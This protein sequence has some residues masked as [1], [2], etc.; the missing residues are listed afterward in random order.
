MRV[1]DLLIC[2]SVTALWAAAAPLHAQEDTGESV[3]SIT[4]RGE[5][6][7]TFDGRPLSG[8]LVLK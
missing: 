4:V 1:P 3:D 5:V 8:V 7:S 2:V 6:L